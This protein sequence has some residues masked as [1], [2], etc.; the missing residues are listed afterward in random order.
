MYYLQSRY[1]NPTLDRFI[2]S[3]TIA[4]T[5]QGLLG[6]NTFAYCG[7]NPI[8]RSDTGGNWWDTIVD[9][10]SLILSIYDVV[11]NPDDIGAWVGLVLDIVDVVVPVVSGLGEAADAA[12]AARKLTDKATDAQ[13][14]AKVVH[15][16][17]LDYPGVNYGYVLSDKTTGEIVKF[18]ESIHPERRYTK[19]YLNGDNPIGKPLDMTVVISGTKRDVHNWQHMQIVDYYEVVGELPALNKSKW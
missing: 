11:Q 4:A 19:K 15:G 9:A 6:N 1:Y 14:A 2:N 18:G 3:D 17:S 13:K 5:G 8:S 12:N 16:N 10:A 7:N